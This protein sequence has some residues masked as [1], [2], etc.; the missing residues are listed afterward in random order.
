MIESSTVFAYLSE[1]KHW[2]I[3]YLLFN[4]EQGKM[5][6]TFTQIKHRFDSVSSKVSAITYRKLIG[7]IIVDNGLY[8][9]KYHWY[10]QI[11]L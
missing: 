11:E 7:P 8:G 1:H 9:L 4:T 2:E 6:P 5:F 10:N 3:I